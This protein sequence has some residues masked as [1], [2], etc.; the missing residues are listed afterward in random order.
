MKTLKSILESVSV[1]PTKVKETSSYTEIWWQDLGVQLK[2]NH[3]QPLIDGYITMIGRNFWDESDKKREINIWKKQAPY[4][5]DGFSAKI[6]QFGENDPIMSITISGSDPKDKF[7]S[8]RSVISYIRVPN[9]D[10]KEFSADE[11]AEFVNPII[12]K[13]Q[14]KTTKAIKYM[15]TNW[16]LPNEYTDYNK[17]IK[18]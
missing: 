3:Q 13:L 7:N 8:F 4:V 12:D 14:N 5:F 6:T 9:P 10:K 16:N 18:L 11:L 1:K 15:A 17:F 2:K